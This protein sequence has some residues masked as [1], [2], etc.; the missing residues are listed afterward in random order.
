[1]RRGVSEY[2]VAPVA[3]AAADRGHRGPLLRP[4]P[5]VRRSL[6]RLRRRTRRGR[7]LVGGPQHGL[8]DLR[9]DRSQHRHR[10]LRPAVRH[11]GPGLQP[12]PA[13]RRRRRAW[14]AGP[15]RLGADGPDD[16]PLHRQ[17]EPV[18]RAGDPG[19]RLGHQSGGLRGGH[20]P[21]SFD[22]AIR[23]AGPAASLVRLDAPDADRGRR[24]GRRRDA[25]PAPACATPRT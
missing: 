4:G 9:A 15:P 16:G 24:S 19:C 8:C 3:A 2:L 22:R 12:G 6:D 17:A 21:H 14:P 1:M 25:G 20:Q 11:R 13:E 10:R 23:G 5:A 18:R 7:R